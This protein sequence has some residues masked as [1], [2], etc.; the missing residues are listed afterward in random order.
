MRRLPLILVAAILGVGLAFANG[1]ALDNGDG[2][3]DTLGAYL[4]AHR[5]PLVEARIVTNGNGQ[6]TLML[7]GYVATGYGKRDAEDQARDFMDDPDIEIINRIRVR[8]ELLTLGTGS[9][10]STAAAALDAPS[11]LDS[12]GDAGQQ[13]QEQTASVPAPAEFPDTIGDQQDYANQERDDEFLLS[14]GV[15]FSGVPLAMVIL[16]SGAIMPPLT[17]PFSMAPA[18]QRSWP[19]FANQPPVMFPPPPVI[20]I[21]PPVYQPPNRFAGF[22]GRFGPGYYPSPFPA[23]PTPMFPAT[24]GMPPFPSAIG[25]GFNAGPGFNGFAGHGFPSG[26]AP[27]TGFSGGFGFGGHR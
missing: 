26:F 19:P 9:N 1:F 17:P 11:Q 23:G 6:R 27:S 7:Y 8:P 22:P 16:G 20:V 12:Y 13:G 3:A 14:N 18:Y 4:H 10:N 21:R 25:P 15:G 5:L 24:G 2:S